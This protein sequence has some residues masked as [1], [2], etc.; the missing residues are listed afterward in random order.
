MKRTGKVFS[1]NGASTAQ[2]IYVPSIVTTDENYPFS[3]G[4]EVKI[5]IEG[6]ELRL[7]KA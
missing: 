3:P 7:R 5:I 1:A 6:N 2:S 4:D